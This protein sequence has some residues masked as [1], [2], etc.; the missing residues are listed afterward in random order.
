MNWT[1]RGLWHSRPAE[2][3]IVVWD[4]GGTDSSDAAL[5]QV[6]G[7]IRARCPSTSST[8]VVIAGTV[9]YRRTLSDLI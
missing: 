2:F 3:L 8:V 7:H 6:T 1:L 9:D 5:F 4:V